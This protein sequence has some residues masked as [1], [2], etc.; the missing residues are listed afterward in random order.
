VVERTFA[1]L[2]KCRRLRMALN[3]TNYICCHY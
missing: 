2:V 3:S 1:W